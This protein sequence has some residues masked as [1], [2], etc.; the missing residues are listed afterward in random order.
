M[1]VTRRLTDWDVRQLLGSV[2]NH[3]SSELESEQIKV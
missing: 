2:R 3:P 1:M